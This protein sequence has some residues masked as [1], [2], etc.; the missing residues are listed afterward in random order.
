MPAIT[1][2]RPQ[3]KPTERKLKVIAENKEPL[4][5]NVIAVPDVEN[6]LATVVHVCQWLEKNHLTVFERT[7][8]NLILAFARLEWNLQPFGDTIEDVKPDVVA[9]VLILLAG[10]S[11]ANNAVHGRRAA[12]LLLFFS[13][14]LRLFFFSFFLHLLFFSFFL[15]GLGSSCFLS[16][17]RLLT[18]CDHLRLCRCFCNNGGAR[19]RL[20][21]DRRRHNRRNGAA[22]IFENPYIRHAQILHVNGRVDL[23]LCHV[24]LNMIR[25]VFGQAGD[26]ES[27]YD[28]LQGSAVFHAN[29]GSLQ[30]HR[31]FN[32]QLLVRVQ[33][34]QIKVDRTIC[35]GIELNRAQNAW[36][37]RSVIEFEIDDMRCRGLEKRL[38][39]KLG[40]GH[41]NVF[42]TMAVVDA[43][44]LSQPAKSLAPL[45]HLFAYFGGQCYFRHWCVS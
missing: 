35:H 29:G 34:E 3:P 31:Y 23:Q 16:F 20:L 13:F 40:E 11:E 36:V 25:D 5:W 26:S 18:A 42:L 24:K 28:V 8:T 1:P 41:R 2:F 38:Q 21:Q 37:S 30:D 32:C 12:L 4:E 27:V 44:D 39:R 33:S 45:S 17:F 14:F 6:G 9:S 15:H 10:I 43:R 7:E 22:L 19:F